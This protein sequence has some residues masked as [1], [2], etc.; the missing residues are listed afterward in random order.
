MTIRFLQPWNGYQ[1][2][3]IVTGLSNAAALIASG[4]AS[5][6]LDGANDGQLH[7]AKYRVVNGNVTGLVGPGGSAILGSMT[8]GSW[9]KVPS[10]FRLRLTG[11]G[12]CTLDARD[13][14]GNITPGIAS[15]TASNATDQIEFP[16][17]GN[18]AVEIRATLTGTCKAEVI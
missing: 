17:A 5:A 18:N 12:T 14:L 11:T 2:D 9:M 4:I 15:Y 1:P 10:I 8:S 16:Y 6:D 3:Q 13:S 7:T